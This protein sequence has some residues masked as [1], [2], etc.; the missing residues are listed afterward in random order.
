MRAAKMRFNPTPRATRRALPRSRHADVTR[1][2]QMCHRLRREQR[3]APPVAAREKERARE[4]RRGER[5]R[6]NGWRSADINDY[7]G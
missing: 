1:T 4:R 5:R 6:A 2:S 3:T 7:A